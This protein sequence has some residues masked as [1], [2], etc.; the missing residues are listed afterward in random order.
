MLAASATSCCRGHWI[1]LRASALVPPRSLASPSAWTPSWR[2]SPPARCGAPRGVGEA[3][4]S[5]DCPCSLY[6]AARAAPLAVWP[7][8]CGGAGVAAAAWS[9][10]RVGV[11]FVLDA[12]GALHC[13][14]LC[15]SASSPVLVR[16]PAAAAGERGLPV[17]LAVSRAVRG[18]PGA[19]AVIG[20]AAA[21]FAFAHFGAG[22][23]ATSFA[24]ARDAGT[25]AGARRWSPSAARWAAAARGNSQQCARCSRQCDSWA[26][27]V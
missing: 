18:G 23:L 3:C 22:V 15:V 16:A 20:Y 12:G 8:A 27:A 14:D 19:C 9:S 13:W 10:S 24:N 7:G 1:C 21:G 5:N 6:S 4:A 11:F 2:G 17:A 26:A 25:R